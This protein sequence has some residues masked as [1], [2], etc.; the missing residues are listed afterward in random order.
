MIRKKCRS[1]KKRKKNRWKIQISVSGCGKLT[2]GKRVGCV[3][4]MGNPFLGSLCLLM[5]HSQS[6]RDTV[7]QTV[8]R[9]LSS[10]DNEA[11]CILCWESHQC[12]VTAFTDLINVK[13]EVWKKWCGVVALTAAELV[14]NSLLKVREQPF[15]LLHQGIVGSVCLV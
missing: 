7:Q 3:A 14:V 5:F 10:L 2:A 12:L 9:S 8:N 1:G 4:A 13:Q 11:L 15:F 6:Y